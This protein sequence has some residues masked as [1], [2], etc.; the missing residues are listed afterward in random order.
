MSLAAWLVVAFMLGPLV[1]VVGGSVTE[2]PFVKFPPDGFTLAWYRQLLSRDD[3]FWSFVDSV[4]IATACTAAA[5]L[6]GTLAAAGLYRAPFRGREAFRTF[7]ASPLV[8]PTVITGV[9]LLQVIYLADVSLP[10]TSLIVGHTLITVPY[11]VR[12]IGAG[13][14][15]LPPHIEEAAESLGASPL[16]VLR[17]VTL[18]A[19]A[20]SMAASVIFV[21]ITSFDQATISIFLS[22]PDIMPLP[23]RIYSYID[24]SI[25][26]MVAAVSTLLILFAFALIVLLQKLLG[27]DRAFGTRTP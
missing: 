24:Y 13:F 21:F 20:P 23:V 3:F 17:R 7:V 26:P 25:D 9:A 8:L 1:V 12:T 22:G 11:A 15:G 4:V 5:T 6:I 10:R 2:T 16:R 27:L 18:P 19:I 14:L